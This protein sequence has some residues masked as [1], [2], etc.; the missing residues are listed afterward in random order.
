MN[1][2]H[3]KRKD[4][5]EQNNFANRELENFLSGLNIT[6]TELHVTVPLHGS[7]DL[8]VLETL[9]FNQLRQI[10][11]SDGD[12]TDIVNI[13]PRI[14][15]LI[16]SSNILVNLENLPAGLIHLE[17][18]YNYLTELDVGS[19]SNLS[20]LNVSNNVLERVAKLPSALTEIH[21]NNNHLAHLDFRGMDLLK[22]LHLQDNKITRIE[23]LPNDLQEFNMNNNP[24]VEFENSIYPGTKTKASHGGKEYLESLQEYFKLKR[25]Y[26]TKVREMRRAAFK[27]APNRK[28]GKELA[29]AVKSQ[30]IQCKRP[31]GTLF[32][33]KYEY[34]MAHCG[35]ST[36]PCNL[37]IELFSGLYTS[38][39]FS[40]EDTL[41]DVEV[42]KTEIIK[43]K[44]DAL[45]NYI[46]EEQSVELYK[47]SLESYHLDLD[48][49]KLAK[50][51]Y[52]SL[53]ENPVKMDT[54]EKKRRRIFILNEQLRA[55]L[56]EYQT[57]QNPEII[58]AAIRLQ[59]DQIIPEHKSLMILENE[60]MEM[61]GDVLCK[62]VIVPGK[63][64][65]LH[66][67]P[68]KVV[69]WNKK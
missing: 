35:S 11:F 66:S 16:C 37:K 10:T 31:V 42:A 7:L 23:N 13:P 60:V 28:A 1:I 24:P 32:Q 63:S 4:I 14:T 3:D 18:P 2:I 41:E 59:I 39:T 17:I 9:G 38:G 34:Y 36:D 45:F 51:H 69:H 22:K 6:I 56:K 19:L 48:L 53:Y 61:D 50:D 21:L 25:D 67:E 52:E 43:H 27:K 46:T 30:C 44:L 33:R 47:D 54:I 20:Y 49:L 62:M 57:T 29:S 58:K 5:L 8:A 55:L 65:V 64:D 68:P 12:I 26:E 40:M 15:H